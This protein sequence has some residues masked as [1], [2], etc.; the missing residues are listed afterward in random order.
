MYRFNCFDNV[1]FDATKDAR[2]GLKNT[3]RD[4]NSCSSSVCRWNA[5]GIVAR[6]ELAR[7]A[8]ACSVKRDALGCGNTHFSMRAQ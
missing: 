2:Y 5:V 6:Q 1:S 4:G 3:S 7:T 8:Q